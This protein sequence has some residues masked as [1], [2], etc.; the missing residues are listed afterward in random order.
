MPF[1]EPFVVLGGVTSYLYGVN[2]GKKR[3]IGNS[4]Q[5][6]KI[7]WIYANSTIQKHIFCKKN[8]RLLAYMQKKL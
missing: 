5:R 6:Y 1:F 3:S 7:F 2:E 4:L 8:A